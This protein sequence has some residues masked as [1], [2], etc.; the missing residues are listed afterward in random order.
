MA[1]E[2]TI[3]PLSS[4]A[5]PELHADQE[6]LY[7]DVL[8]FLTD[9]QIPYVVSGAFALQEHTG[10]HRPAKYLGSSRLAEVVDRHGADLIVHGHAHHGSLNGKTTAGIPVHNVAITLLQSQTPAAAYRVFDVYMP[11]LYSA[12]PRTLQSW[13]DEYSE[14]ETSFAS[15]DI[16]CR[17]SRIWRPDYANKRE[18]VR[19]IYMFTILIIILV[20]LLVGA[21]PTWPYSSGWGYY[22][23]GGLGLIVLIVV[24]LLLTGR[25]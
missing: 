11:G 12:T 23:S 9:H 18:I 21:L 10:V 25:V 20:L 7:Q 8:R 5:Q 15:Q 24:I 14:H 16:R 22:P 4:S 2:G 17:A 3:L 1:L 13:P 6:R 19:R